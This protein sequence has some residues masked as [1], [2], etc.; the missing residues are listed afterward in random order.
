VVLRVLVGNI[1]IPLSH[2]VLLRFILDSRY[3]NLEFE[4]GACH[5]FF[6]T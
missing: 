1:F 5:H 6:K 3:W 2:Q 4:H